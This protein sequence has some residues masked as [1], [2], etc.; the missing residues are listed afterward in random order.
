MTLDIALARLMVSSANALFFCANSSYLLVSHP[1]NR[2]ILRFHWMINPTYDPRSSPS[3][4]LLLCQ[5]EWRVLLPLQFGGADSVADP[6]NSFI[7]FVAA[8]CPDP[9]N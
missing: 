6:P 8:Y 1:V 3:F 9:F 4:P 2:I 5:F 7:I